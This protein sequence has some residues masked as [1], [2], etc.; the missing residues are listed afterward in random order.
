[1][2]ATAVH[3]VVWLR[4]DS[5]L[6]PPQTVSGCKYWVAKDTILLVSGF[7]CLKAFT[8]EKNQDKNETKAANLV[9]ALV[10]FSR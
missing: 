9:S 6:T 10:F 1:M 8:L 4:R 5:P 2:P 7:Q 3:Q